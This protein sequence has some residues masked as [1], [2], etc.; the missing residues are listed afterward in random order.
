M[1]K[2]HDSQKSKSQSHQH[3]MEPTNEN[4]ESHQADGNS[5]LHNN[6]G[7][8]LYDLET[9]KSYLRQP[10]A[11]QILAI[12]I[13]FGLTEKQGMKNLKPNLIE[14]KTGEGKSL[15]LAVAACILGLLGIDVYCVCY[16]ELLTKRDYREFSELF[17]KLGVS[18]K[19]TYGMYDNI[20]YKLINQVFDLRHN[21]LDMICYTSNYVHE[22]AR[23]PRRK[24]HWIWDVKN[25]V[26]LVDEVD[27]FFDQ[28]YF[29]SNYRRVVKL[30]HECISRILDQVWKLYKTGGFHTKENVVIEKDDKEDIDTKVRG[31]NMEIIKNSKTYSECQNIFGFWMPVIDQAMKVMIAHVQQPHSGYI[32]RDDQIGYYKEDT[33]SFTTRHGYQTM[34][35]L[36]KEYE[37][38]KVSKQA[39]EQKQ[40]I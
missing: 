5:L 16:G 25:T 27:V 23:A 40:S 11:T 21:V 17:I 30:K 18:K 7:S 9:C 14:V 8:S 24:N 31:M 34:F 2:Q 38:N 19:V 22:S 33:I 1:K 15:I 6:V 28:R 37:R 36:Y 39:L 10:K 13:L 12:M 26:L 20:C 29:G 3:E 32:V 35:A 4:K